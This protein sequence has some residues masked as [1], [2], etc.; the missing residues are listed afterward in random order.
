MAK[1]GDE[2]QHLYAGVPYEPA[3]LL[4][5]SAK[6]RLSHFDTESWCWVR[7]QPDRAELYTEGLGDND[8]KTHETEALSYRKEGRIPFA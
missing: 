8:D 7:S 5:V 1:K 4:G 3:A 2:T 6:P